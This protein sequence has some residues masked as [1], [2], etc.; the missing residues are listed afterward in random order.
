MILNRKSAKATSHVSLVVA[1]T[2]FVA[3][4]ITVQTQGIPTDYLM[5]NGTQICK[6]GFIDLFTKLLW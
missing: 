4:V 5:E 2:M 6:A 3:L 1:L